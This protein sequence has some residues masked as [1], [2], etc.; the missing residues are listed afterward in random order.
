MSLTS[1]LQLPGAPNL[2]AAAAK[3]Q[4]LLGDPQPPTGQLQ[5]IAVVNL[6]DVPWVTRWWAA[7]WVGGREFQWGPM[8]RTM[9]IVFLGS[10]ILAQ[11][12]STVQSYSTSPSVGQNMIGVAVTY[13]LVVV[14]FYSWRQSDIL[15]IHLHPAVTGA[16]WIHGHLGTLF[17]IPSMG[18]NYLGSFLSAPTL[19]AVGGSAIPD[20][21]AAARPASFWGAAGIEMLTGLLFVYAILQNS[22]ILNHLG[23]MNADAEKKKGT[24]A[25]TSR[26][27][28]A[29]LAIP[30]GVAI[31]YGNGLYTLCNPTVYFGPAFNIGF[32]LPDAATWT[33]FTLMPGLVAIAAW[34]IHLLTWNVQGISQPEF[35]SAVALKE[36]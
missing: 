35:N 32:H 4:A 31:G 16:E 9:F 25:V 3:Q 27:A 7:P 1:K 24:R 23:G 22:S 17:C 12:V 34:A 6:D 20:Y 36:L 14:F 29:G 15:P 26:G 19:I 2:A 21:A 10:W 33:I 30:I 13:A 28:I 8:L 18:M 5:K 11:S